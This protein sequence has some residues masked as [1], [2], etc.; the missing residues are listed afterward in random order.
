MEI[1]LTFHAVQKVEQEI[2]RQV[3]IKFQY[4]NTTPF[5]IHLHAGVWL[6]QDIKGK[7]GE[8]MKVKFRTE[9]VLCASRKQLTHRILYLVSIDLVG[10]FEGKFH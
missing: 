9:S 4:K 8:N 2:E 10:S 7:Y 3:N 6:L 1:Q 5:I